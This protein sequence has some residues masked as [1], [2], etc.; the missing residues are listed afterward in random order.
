MNFESYK[1]ILICPRDKD[2]SL[3]TGKSYSIDFTVDD[4]RSADRVFFTG[5]TGIFYQWKTEPDYKYLYRRLDDSL[6][7]IESNRAQ[8][9]LDMSADNF[10]YPKI[11]HKKIIWWPRF[12]GSGLN[13]E[14]G[15]SAK[16]ENLKICDGGYLHFLIEVRFLK[17]GVDKR[18]A[19]TEP[20]VTAKIDIP[21]GSYDWQDLMIPV[22]FQAGHVA[23]VCVYLEGKNYS[24]R[25]FCES[26]FLRTAGGAN[27]LADF[28][29]FTEARPDFNWIGVNL[30]KKETPSLKI[31]LNG[32]TIHDGEIF[33][34]CHRYSEWEVTIPEGVAKKGLNTLTFTHTSDYRDAPPYNLHEIG[35]VSVRRD[36]LISCPEVVSAGEPFAVL[37]KTQ[38]DNAQYK[39][40]NA[41]EYLR[42]VSPLV[43]GE[44]GLNV[45]HLVCDKPQ[46][47]ISFTL[48]CDDIKAECNI[49][50][51][52]IR[53]DDGVCTG[54]G[55][56]V[57]VNQND[58][59]FE[60]YLSWYVSNNVGN[61]LTF[62]PTYR[63]SGSKAAD[64][65]LWRKTADLLDELG[66]KYVHML[67]GREHQ[68][69]DANPT[70]AE[71]DSKNFQGRQTHELDGQ[72]VYWGRGG[73][74]DPT[75]SIN[76]QMF[77]DLFVRMFIKDP[78]RTNMRYT[79]DTYKA[80][81]GKL[82]ICR[83]YSVKR[84]MEAM[85]NFVVNGLAACRYDS[86][87]HTGPAAI[88]KYFYQAGYSW[89]GAELMYS[90]TE[91]T[92]SVLRGAAKVYGG[93][94]GA[95]LATQWSTTPHDTVE[96]AKRYRLALYT[97]Y[98]EDLD[99]INTEE[100]LWRME[101]YFADHNRHGVACLSHLKQHQDFYKYLATHTRSGSFYTP[102][103]FLHGRYEGWKLFGSK[104]STW[105]RLDC[106]YTDAENGWDMLD[107]FYPQSKPGSL[108]RH[109]CPK[110]KPI[111]HYS[112]TPNGSI[113]VIPIEAKSFCEYPL[114]CAIGYNK[115][116]DEDMDKLSAYV[117]GGGTL[118]I[119]TAQLSVTTDRSDIENYSL[120]YTSHPFAKQI[121][122]LSEFAEDTYSGNRVRV[123]KSIPEGAKVLTATDSGAALI[124]ELPVGLGKAIVLNT[125]EYAGN[126]A[127][128]ELVKKTLKELGAKAFDSERVWAEGDDV[129]QFTAYKQENGDVHFYFLSTDWYCADEPTR[130][131]KLRI[132]ND[133]YDV[134]ISFG[135]M[136]KAVVSNG[137]GAY[138]ENEDCDVLEISNNEVR[139]QGCGSAELCVA[140]GGKTER[141][142]V[143]FS[144]ASVKTVKL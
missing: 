24:G 26:P 53:E 82:E 79:P 23:N 54:T 108:Y 12:Y 137:I 46:N 138:F 116:L 18:I 19:Y 32:V 92:N 129:I 35:L 74:S 28:T 31:E 37:V 120:S 133:M 70:Y 43:C 96:H 80:A 15:L 88:F 124:Y 87:R 119:G 45:L 76:E 81:A 97:A 50:R 6:S 36:T 62:R 121:S 58:T 40:E 118:F 127:I 103:A 16:A 125:L 102:V 7:S 30:S 99:D 90:T 49:S 29:T 114:L 95:H 130:I 39:L 67:D 142:C 109:G 78:Q 47:D 86:T 112:G 57:Y 107:A 56:A 131:A 85:A 91:V 105:G 13:W 73:T 25:V 52:V 117:N 69:G 115:A 134:N 63:W 68:G 126:P 128:Y 77:Y 22:E 122:T 64:G 66:M 42:A 110:D 33:E 55:D 104:N 123:C 2:I 100:G 72:F 136:I 3:K 144:D 8:Y 111:G 135:R 139:V 143:D 75:N 71:M 51:C 83:D 48:A 1:Q 140:R 11:A 20:D 132:G 94:K 101:E 98:M 61:L 17:D 21:E 44:A 65:R 14:F 4:A 38:K 113:D 59:D 93:K 27:I 60:N 141:L 5:E 41:P 9:A 106:P 89:T 84:D 10:N 34:R